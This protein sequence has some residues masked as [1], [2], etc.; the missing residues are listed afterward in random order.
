MEYVVETEAGPVFIVS[1]E[2]ADPF[3]NGAAV[4]L[5]FPAAGPVLLP[6]G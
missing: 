1:R 6:A 2:T 3:P 4:G 5:R